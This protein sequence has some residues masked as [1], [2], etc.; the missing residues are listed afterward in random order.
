MERT[1]HETRAILASECQ[2]ADE[3]AS[4]PAH[5]HSVQ[6]SSRLLFEQPILNLIV[7]FLDRLHLIKHLPSNG[8]LTST[9]T[10]IG[11]S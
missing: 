3:D 7:F 11:L 4:R 9:L 5:D 2:C 6:M 10:R 8:N 1:I